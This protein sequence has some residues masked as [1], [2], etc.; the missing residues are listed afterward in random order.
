[1]KKIASTEEKKFDPNKAEPTEE[2][3]EI[4]NALVRFVPGLSA[5]SVIGETTEIVKFLLFRTVIFGFLFLYNKDIFSGDLKNPY[6]LVL[7]SSA[8]VVLLHI[9]YL[10]KERNNDFISSLSND[11]FGPFVLMLPFG[12]VALLIGGMVFSEILLLTYNIQFF[13]IDIVIGFLWFITV[14]DKNI[15]SERNKRN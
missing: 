5:L 6:F 12:I 10:I 7:V 2:D 13:L 3:K 15:I 9:S 4:A 14:T 1:M 8:S 11:F